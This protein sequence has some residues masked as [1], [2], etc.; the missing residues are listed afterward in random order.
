TPARGWLEVTV[1]APDGRTR[2]RLAFYDSVRL[3]Q[4]LAD[5]AAHGQ[6]HYAEPNL[7]LLTEVS[8]ANIRR[9][10]AEL[11]AEG[12]FDSIQPEAT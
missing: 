9:A 12:Y 1:R 6:V 5:Y 2:Y 3:E 8:T 11:A 4:T 10:V 7:V